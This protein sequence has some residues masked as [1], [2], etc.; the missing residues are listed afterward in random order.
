MGTPPFA[1]RSLERLLAG[2]HEIATVVTRPDKPRGRGMTVQAS[3][4]KQLAEKHGLPVLAPASAKDAAL[5]TRLR[6]IAPDLAVVVAYGRILPRSVLEIPRLGCINAHASLLPRLRGA[7]PIERAILEGFEETGV[8]IMRLVEEMDAGP[9]VAARTLPIGPETDGGELTDRLS[10]VAA[11]LLVEVVDSIARGEATF[12]EQNSAEATYAPPIEKAE[13]EIRWNDPVVRVDRVVRA[14]RPR[15]GAFTFD[16]ERRLKIE[17]GRIGGRSD[18]DATPG[19][20]VEVGEDGVVVA[21]GEGAFVVHRVQP[22]GRKAMSAAAWARGL[23]RAI[24]RRI[25]VRS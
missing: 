10:H 3:A 18:A 15:P 19:T 7:A 2:R 13:A 4:V 12:T 14:F 21:C 25:G 1:A 5:A 23:D 24:G 9:I 20:I 17:H 11:D 22:E 6:E 8:T 16:G